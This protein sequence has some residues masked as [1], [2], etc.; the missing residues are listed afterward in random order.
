MRDRI[1]RWLL[2]A[3]L[4]AVALL[5][6][7]G[8]W[9][10]YSQGKWIAVYFIATLASVVF[11]WRAP[12]LPRLPRFEMLFAF[13]LILAAGAA[14]V[15]HNPRGYEF[16]LLDR[17]SFFAVFLYSWVAFRDGRVS[18]PDFW[19]P[20]ALAVGAVS[21]YGL[22]QMWEIGFPGEMPYLAVASTFGHSNNTAQALALMLILWWCI[23]RAPRFAWVRPVVSAGALAYFILLRGRSSLIAMAIA[24]AVI[25]WWRYREQGRKLFRQRALWISAGLMLAILVGLQ[26]GNGKSFDDL[27]HFRVFAEKSSMLQWRMDIWAQTLKLIQEHPMGIGPGRFEYGFV[28]YHA[29]GTT[30][31]E[32]ALAGNPHSEL[33]RY[34]A[35]DGLPLTVFYLAALIYFL[36]AWWRKREGAAIIAPLLAFLAFEATCQFPFLNPFPDYLLAVVFGFMAATVRRES[37][38]FPRVGGRIAGALVFCVLAFLTVK[39]TLARSY[40]HSRQK[41]LSALSCRL[42]PLNWRSCLNAARLS[43]ADHEL[44]KAREFTEEILYDDPA[45]FAAIRHLSIIAFQQ[46]DRLEGCFLLWK[47]DSLFHGRS[48]LHDRFLGTC[49]KKW[50]SYF[51]LRRPENYNPRYMEFLAR[52]KKPRFWE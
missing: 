22:W 46:G 40:E 38:D 45:N 11:L 2:P 12:R 27:I 1:E 30:L 37:R 21:A 20:L 14:V 31:S 13:S 6:W 24:L 28:P 41:E 9:A 35:E 4:L 36:M 51:E 44:G 49:P 16:A 26:L 23:P 3:G 17:L 47:Y 34:S 42:V 32:G 18:W 8:A 52:T 39:T 5:F 25:L 48:S 33:L 7:P 29:R 10:P 15:W 43:L 50:I 19:W